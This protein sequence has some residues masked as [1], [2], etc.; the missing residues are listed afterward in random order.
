MA[1]KDLDP[2]MQ[3]G[4]V[5]RAANKVIT[6]LEQVQSVFL[7]DLKSIPTTRVT[8]KQITNADRLPVYEYGLSEEGFRELETFLR[9]DMQRLVL[10]TNGQDKPSVWYLDE[11]SELAVRGG[12]L[13]AGTQYNQMVRTG[14]KNGMLEESPMGEIKPVNLLLSESYVLM[15]NKAQLSNWAP[16]KNM[17]DDAIYQIMQVVRAGV[18]G[19]ESPKA[20]AKKIRERFDVSKNRARKIA[21]TEMNKAFNGGKMQATKDLGER[22]GYRSGV[23]HIS[24]LTPRTR[25]SHA[26]RHGNAYTVEAQERWWDEGANRINCLCSTR[27]VVL[28]SRGQPVAPELIERIRDQ[29]SVFGIEPRD[30]D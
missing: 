10:Q 25:T 29:Q 2:T 6:R 22:T 28:D 16:I 9:R 23:I 4:N 8:V 27:P 19:G 24:A 18:E 26:A 30:G 14:L 3:S 1:S 12:Y 11:N 7:K 17:A 5:K 20:V 13:D 15:V 21:R